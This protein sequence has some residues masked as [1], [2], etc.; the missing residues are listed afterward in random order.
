MRIH[1]PLS[2][3]VLIVMLSGSLPV[4]AGLIINEIMQSNIDCIMDDL[5]EFP[6]SWVEL[7]ND[8][9]Y[10]V[11][12]AS[13]SLSDG[14]SPSGSYRLPALEVPPGGY[15]I[16]YCDKEG[17][18]MHA[19]F[20]IDSGKGASIYLFNGESVADKVTGMKKQPAPNI[21]YG[22]ISDGADEW[23]YQASPTP[24]KA[25]CGTLCKEILG[26]PVFSEM[27][28]VL[29]DATMIRLE[30]SV[31]EGSPEGT[32]IR[33]TTNGTEPTGSSA[34][35]TSPI[36]VASTMTVRAKLFCPGYMSPR[37]ATN[38][39]I[40][41]GRDMTMPLVSM[42]TD[43]NYFYSRDKGIYNEYNN[44]TVNGVSYSNDWRRPV[45]VEIFTEIG[46][47]SVVNQLCETR[48][49]GGASRSEALK[50]LVV[51]ANKR[52]GEKRLSY[53][54]FPDDA[55]G[56][57]DWKSI[58]LRNAG[59]DF[60]YLY[61]RDALIQSNVGRRADLDWQPYRP[62]IFMINGE[63]KGILNIRSRTNE[64]YVYTFYDGEEDIDLIEN[65][66]ELK[67]GSWDNFNAFR[68]FYSAS[69]HTIDE[70]EKWMDT[71]EFANLMVMQL[72]HNNLDF[73]GNN[74]VMWRP[75]AVGGRWRW[76]AKDTDFGL[77][78]YDR[79]YDYRIFDWLY[80]NSFDPDNNWANK[81]EHTLLF[82]RLMEVPEFRDMFIDRCA[83]YMGDFLN[84]LTLG[85]EI[86]KMAS[87]IRYEYTDYHRP[88]FNRWW[89]VYDEEVAKGKAW[90]ND[91]T[92]F[93]YT[94][95]ADSY[96]LGSPQPLTID[97]GRADDV[98][99][100]VNGISLSG[101]SF[102]G[103]YFQG[104]NITIEGSPADEATE[105]SGWRVTTVRGPQS[106]TAVYPGAKLVISIPAGTSVEVQSLV[107]DK[108]G[109]TDV[110]A[111]AIDPW[112]PIGIF[113]LHGRCMGMYPSL[114]EASSSLS[115]GIYMARQGGVV[116]KIA[117][118]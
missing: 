61:F 9:A 45:N 21:A 42:V 55:P 87:A 66:W 71:S 102:D 25:N 78:L 44:G 111:D 16:V 60:N 3:A 84:G 73:P 65:W 64:D 85:E 67:A 49:K 106:G 74:I 4:R 46:K 82:R 81:P 26:S 40:F 43:R 8:G 79:A 14:D 96:N 107:A 114:S 39:Y 48:V 7:Y 33:F 35:Y 18:G 103:M 86:D 20:R 30:L 58:E 104:R 19:D 93:F 34:C 63:Y 51:Y 47:G 83:V 68:D 112:M 69:G 94:H 2:R 97:A 100:A 28:R 99:L 57:V 115:S 13:Y 91:R 108:S 41:L 23:G 118:R 89:P 37:S 116:T 110:R 36:T 32:E 56:L 12:L 54:F 80:D 62:A 6:D 5:N 22:R 24:G 76:I 15:V 27:G 77:G 117:V 70:Y 75:R 105:I 98:A 1:Y 92:G 101:R 88:L 109:M 52:F 29:S 59:N 113:D 53:E 50:S 11:D 72:Y 31:P 90:A 17:K 38:S 95:L 10:A